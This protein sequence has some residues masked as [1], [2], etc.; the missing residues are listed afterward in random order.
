[1]FR[2]AGRGAHTRDVDDPPLR[3]L[4][5]RRAVLGALLRARRPLTVAEIVEQLAPRMPP[6]K[7]TPK[8]VADVLRF[9]V[10]AGRVQRL[11]RGVYVVYPSTLSPSTR[12]R[13]LNWERAQRYWWTT[14]R[15]W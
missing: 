5:V 2:V 10:E 3:P 8:R 9:Q 11:A 13:C 14:T 15:R 12:W 1:V 7:L 6:G 4:D